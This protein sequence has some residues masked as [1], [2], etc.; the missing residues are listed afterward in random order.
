MFYKTCPNCG[1]NLDCGESCDCTKEKNHSPAERSIRA[2]AYNEVY[3]EEYADTYSRMKR[4][5]LPACIANHIAEE[6]AASKAARIA[7]SVAASYTTIRR[8]DTK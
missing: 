8:R 1:A 7:D 4:G 2:V 6:A 5:N 3:Q